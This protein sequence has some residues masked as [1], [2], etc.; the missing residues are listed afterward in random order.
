MPACASSIPPCR[1]EVRG[2][3][4]VAGQQQHEAAAERVAVDRRHRH[5]YRQQMRHHLRDGR[6]QCVPLVAGVAGKG[7]RIEPAENTCP[8]PG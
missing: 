4:V 5:R 3:A 6:H 8:P 1:R 7:A 2:N